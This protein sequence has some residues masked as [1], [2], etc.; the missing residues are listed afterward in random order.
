M[1]DMQ[2]SGV[3]PSRRALLR[4]AAWTAPVAVAVSAS[5]A[6][7]ASTRVD[8]WAQAR[9][10][11]EAADEMRGDFRLYLGERKLTFR[12][13]FGNRG[14]EVVPAGTVVGFGLPFVNAWANDL[15]ITDG[16]GMLLRNQTRSTEG[17]A[18]EHEHSFQRQWWFYTLGA[19]IQPGQQFDVTFTVTL[20]QSN[21]AAM[22][23][24]RVRTVASIEAPSGVTDAV[25]SNNRDFS[26]S[27]ALF[28][29]GNEGSG[30]GGQ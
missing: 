10:P 4:T 22:D 20:L 21:N 27:Y 29:K 30:S 16:S 28:N 3:A 11:V 25:S 19:P 6:F 14:T 17:V 9:L 24:W 5:P 1:H 26:D 7:A 2:N 23:F 8:L 15:A 18:P 12:Y 13:T